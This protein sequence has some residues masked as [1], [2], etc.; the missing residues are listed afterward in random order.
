MTNIS[1]PTSWLQCDFDTLESVVA[2]LEPGQVYDCSRS[3][4]LVISAFKVWDTSGMYVDFLF[5]FV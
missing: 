1:H 2:C 5:L 4:S 3:D